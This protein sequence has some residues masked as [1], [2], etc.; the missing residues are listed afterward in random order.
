MVFNAADGTSLIED[1][2]FR[3][4]VNTN[5]FL[6]ADRTRYI[7]EAY[8]LVAYQIM[9]ADG[10][11]SWDDPNHINQ[12]IA[13][14]NLIANQSE[15]NIFSNAPSALQNWLG[16][17]RVD[18]MDA[19]GVGI[20]L[21][22]ID[23]EDFKGTAQ[24]EMEKSPSIP[25]AFDFTGTIIRLYPAPD[26]DYPLGMTMW[27][28]RAPSYFTSTDTA[29]SPGFDVRF[30]SFLS[31]YAAHQWNSIK[32]KDFSLQGVIQDMLNKIGEIYAVE[33]NKT[34]HPIISRAKQNFK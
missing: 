9:K 13:S 19:G 29:K 8:N 16:I 5:Q 2:T 25:Y 7:N 14:T 21:Q 33:R 6:L 30:H 24:S 32:K 34:E 11:M 28:N 27:F 3:T 18:I 12:P 20:Q 10:R 22:P 23:Q 1:I 31:I 17:Y 26:Y 4:G 15:Y